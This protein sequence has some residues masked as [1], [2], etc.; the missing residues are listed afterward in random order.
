M[1]AAARL[2]P[3]RRLDPVL[4]PPPGVAPTAVRWLA[5]D[6]ADIEPG[7]P[8]ATAISEL[9]LGRELAL[10]VPPHPTDAARL[11]VVRIYAVTPRDTPGPVEIAIDGTVRPLLALAPAE[12]FE[13]AVAPGHHVVRV[14]APAGTR[15]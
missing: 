14:D 6:P 3:L 7:V 13:V 8:G 15:A 11:A 10:D 12:V 5:G 4:P 9:P 1:L 2:A